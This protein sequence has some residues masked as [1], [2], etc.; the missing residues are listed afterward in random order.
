MSNKQR[1][2]VRQDLLCLL[3]KGQR[4]TYFPNIHQN[5][6]NNPFTVTSPIHILSMDSIHFPGNFSFS[7]SEFPTLK[8]APNLPKSSLSTS[9]LPT[10]CPPSSHH[11]TSPLSQ[12]RSWAFPLEPTRSKLQR[13]AGHGLS[14]TILPFLAVHGGKTRRSLRGTVVFFLWLPSLWE[15]LMKNLG[16][17]NFSSQNQTSEL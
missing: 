13:K 16:G 6:L 14:S 17:F 12:T 8:H 4:I 5:I 2:K 10:S 9:V 3:S 1:L 15:S 11:T 7:Y